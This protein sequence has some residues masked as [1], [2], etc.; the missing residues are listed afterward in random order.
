MPNLEICDTFSRPD[1]AVNIMTGICFKASSSLS[2]PSMVTPSMTGMVMSSRMRSGFSRAAAA[3]PSSPLAASMTTQSY[4]MRARVTMSRM[5]RLSSTLRTLR[6]ISFGV[7][8]FELDLDQ[9]FLL[10]ANKKTFARPKLGS[11]VDAKGRGSNNGGRAHGA[12]ESGVAEPRFET[13]A[14]HVGHLAHDVMDLLAALDF[15]EVDGQHGGGD[16]ARQNVRDVQKHVPG[17]A[18]AGQADAADDSVGVFRV[19]VGFGGLDTQRKHLLKNVP[20]RLM[21]QRL[22]VKG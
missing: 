18:F 8:E 14:Q 2:L 3:R 7:V 17:H 15:M 9:E 6:V 12:A 16:L 11:S 19:W 4:S 21:D 5:V 1:S 22:D 20:Q 10:A 13:A